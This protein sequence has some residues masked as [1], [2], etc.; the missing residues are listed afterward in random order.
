ML[1]DGILPWWIS[2]GGA[3]VA[4]LIVGACTVGM[5]AEASA[6]AVASTAVMTALMIVVMSIDLVPIGYELHGTVLAGIV[7]GPRMASVSALG[8]NVVRA[9]VGDGAVTN[10]GVNTVLTWLE[11]AGG[12]VAFRLLARGQIARRVALA[13]GL[14]TVASLAS[15]TIIYVAV[16]LAAGEAAY[17]AAFAELGEMVDEAGR[18]PNLGAGTFAAITLISGAIGWT[19]EGLATGVL[20]AFIAR[21]RPGLVRALRGDGPLAGRAEL[22]P[23]RGGLFDHPV[24]DG[25]DRRTTSTSPDRHP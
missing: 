17:H 8:F 12:F 1:P 20:L 16:M 7:V 2:V 22:D 19:I 24:A 25:S 15:V 3:V 14:A 23:A 10:L 18:L 9:L 6:K 21:A 5:Q 4:I 11:M 13:G